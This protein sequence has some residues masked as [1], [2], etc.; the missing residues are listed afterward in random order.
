MKVGIPL[1]VSS[2]IVGLTLGIFCL[3]SGADPVAG[4]AAGFFGTLCLN[5]FGYWIWLLFD[6]D[7]D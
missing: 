2:F 7:W 1:L 4:F 5:G 6:S 3:L